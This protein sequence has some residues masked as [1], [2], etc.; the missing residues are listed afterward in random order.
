[1]EVLTTYRRAIF[2]FAMTALLWMSCGIA[3]ASFDP[4]EW[5]RTT[6]TVAAIVWGIL[7]FFKLVVPLVER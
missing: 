3:E 5:T 4:T 6:R 2:A 7:L 1:M